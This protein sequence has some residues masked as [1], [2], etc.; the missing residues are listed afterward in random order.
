MDASGQIR[1]TQKPKDE[2]ASP[3]LTAEDNE[4]VRVS[5]VN[6][7]KDTFNARGYRSAEVVDKELSNKRLFSWRENNRIINQEQDVSNT[8]TQEPLNTDITKLFLSNNPISYEALMDQIIYKWEELKGRELGLSRAYTY[9]DTF[10][11]DSVL[12]E[13]PQGLNNIIFKSYIKHSKI[14]L[15]QVLF[16]GRFFETLSNPVTPFSHSVAES[17]SSYAHMQGIISAP[18]GSQY[19]LITTNPVSTII[20]LDGLEIKVGDLGR[21]MFNVHNTPL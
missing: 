19:M 2:A 20:E 11:K 17:W 4:V 10:E 13:I 9:N 3:V 16:L 15:P 7:N 12:V 18:L 14:A 21:I 8:P 6:S 5:P 1:T